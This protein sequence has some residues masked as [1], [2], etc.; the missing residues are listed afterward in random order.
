MLWARGRCGRCGLETD[1]RF[2]GEGF[3]FRVHD[4]IAD[5]ALL[6]RLGPDVDHAD[7]W[8]SL[9]LAGLVVVAEELVA[10]AHREHAGAA[11]HCFLEWWL[12]ELEEVF[13]DERLLAILA[14]SEEEDVDLVHLRD[15]A[16]AELDQSRLVSTPLRALEQR[17]DVAAVAV[18]IHEVGI[19][20]AYGE[21]VVGPWHLFYVSQY[22]LAH[23]RRT[24]SALRSSMAV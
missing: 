7:T 21:D 11:V 24:S 2:W 8:E 1:Q 19:E 22:G 16:A 13:V 15:G 23:P 5:E 20:P 14:A 6:P 10:A 9:A 4:D 12:L 18:D 17:E 3:D